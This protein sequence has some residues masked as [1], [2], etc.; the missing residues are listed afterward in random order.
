MQYENSNYVKVNKLQV[1]TLNRTYTSFFINHT[2][3]QTIDDYKVRANSSVT[4][5][6]QFL[7]LSTFRPNKIKF[8]F[9]KNISNIYQEQFVPFTVDICEVINGIRQVAK[10]GSPNAFL[11]FLIQPVWGMIHQPGN[12]V[13]TRCPITP[14]CISNWWFQTY[15]TRQ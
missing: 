6:I 8:T 7:P 1:E 2:F 13:P 4:T 10:A 14:V 3:L 12:K 9:Y 5:P 15:F 11:A